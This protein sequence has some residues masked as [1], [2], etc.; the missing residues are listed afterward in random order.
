M[1]PF[2]WQLGSNLRSIYVPFTFHVSFTYCVRTREAY[3]LTLLAI[4]HLRLTRAYTNLRAG[5]TGK[6]K[7]NR[8]DW[9]YWSFSFFRHSGLIYYSFL[10]HFTFISHQF[11]IFALHFLLISQAV[12][13]HF[14]SIPS[15]FPPCFLFISHSF[16]IHVLLMLY[17]FPNIFYWVSCN[18]SID[19]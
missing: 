16:P 9:N 10:M 7:R 14:P 18:L 17:R 8:A 13:I 6:R 4:A 5:S 19:F 1:G 2:C 11:P 15:S 3:R 12:F